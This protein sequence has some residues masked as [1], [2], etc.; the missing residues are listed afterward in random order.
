MADFRILVVGGGKMGEAIFGGWIAS[1]QAPANGIGADDFVVVEPSEDRRVYLEERYG[2]SCVADALE[3]EGRFDIVLLSVKPQVMMSV[4]DALSK[5][6]RFEGENAPL[7]VSIAAGMTVER[8]EG[9]LPAGAR[10]VRTMPNTPLLVGAGATA[11]CAG[12]QASSDDVTL[13]RDLFACLGKAFVIQE[14]L[15]DTVCAL[16]GSGP[17]YVAAMIEAL[18]DGAVVEGLEFEFAEELAL[19]TVLG[20]A[21]L[22][23]QTGQS[24]E[25]TRLN[26]CSPGGTTLA[27]LDAMNAR[28]FAE[29]FKAGVSAAVARAKELAA[30]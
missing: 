29:V 2:V 12:S 18:R 25:I 9:A 17:A 14:E 1:E 4:L 10:L 30:C 21:L 15:I 22:M 5:S 3:P 27:A 20:T 28:D 19:Q 23:E 8:L 26:V 16:S 11:A 13:V 6:G 24:A 7:F